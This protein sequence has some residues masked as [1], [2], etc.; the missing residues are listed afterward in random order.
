VHI[1]IFFSAGSYDV[2]GW[3]KVFEKMTGHVVGNPQSFIY[4]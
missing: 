4:S 1:Y 2:V 3:H